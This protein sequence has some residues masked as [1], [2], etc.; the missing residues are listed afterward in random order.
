[1][2]LILRGQKGSK[3]TITEM[4]GNLSYLETLALGSSGISG[5][6]GTDAIGISGY[7]GVDGFSGSDGASGISGY[8]GV[9]GGGGLNLDNTTISFA[10]DTPIPDG[11]FPNTVTGLSD[12]DENYR[13][14]LPFNVWFLGIEYSVVYLVSN[15]YITFGDTSSSSYYD[16][17]PH[18][19]PVPAIFLGAGDNSI[20]SYRFGT[21]GNYFAIQYNGS[22]NTSGEEDSPG[23]R[24][25]IVFDSNVPDVI[26]VTSMINNRECG[27]VFGI[28]SGEDWIEQFVLPYNDKRDDHFYT[29]LIISP[30]TTQSISRMKFV[31]PGVMTSF[32]DPSK[33]IINIDPLGTAGIGICLSGD[34]QATIA[35]TESGLTLTTG[36]AG[37]SVNIAPNGDVSIQP[38]IRTTNQPGRGYTVDIIGGSAQ[39]TVSGN[40]IY[41]GG[42]VNIFGGNGVGISGYS[43]NIRLSSNRLELEANSIQFF[44]NTIEVNGQAVSFGLLSD[45]YANWNSKRVAGTLPLGSYIMVTDIFDLGGI[46]MTNATGDGFMTSAFGGFYNQDY[47][48]NGSTI[49]SDL[50]Y[51]GIVELT[52]ITPTKNV[53]QWY[54]GLEAY[55]IQCDGDPD[56]I[57]PVGSLITGSNSS[58]TGI[59]ISV[60]GGEFDTHYGVYNTSTT[61]FV[62]GDVITN[63]VNAATTTV[64]DVTARPYIEDGSIVFF[65]NQHFVI[66]LIG[67][68]NGYTP[69]D[70]GDAYALLPRQFTAMGYVVKWDKI[71]Y[72]FTVPEV[73]QRIDAVTNCIVS[74]G[75]NVTNMPWGCPGIKNILIN[76]TDINP[77]NVDF[78]NNIGT[79]SGRTS[80]NNHSVNL[81][82]NRG[83]IYFDITGITQ[84]L[85]CPTNM[86]TINAH[87]IGFS[88]G[89]NASNNRGSIS[90]YL[91][92][93]ATVYAG[94]NKG[95]IKSRHYDESYTVFYGNSG[96]INDCVFEKAGF[97]YIVLDPGFY[98]TSCKF[99]GYEEYY[100]PIDKSYI[101]KDLSS[102]GS[103][104]DLV[105]DITGLHTID[106]SSTENTFAGI[107][108]L[109][110]TNTYESIDYIIF[111]GGNKF[112]VKMV[113][114]GMLTLNFN[115]IPAATITT[116]QILMPGANLQLESLKS[117]WATFQQY[118]SNYVM[119]IDA[120]NYL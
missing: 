108:N 103:S 77:S 21:I 115:G 53:G 40:G 81:T 51:S 9:D 54:P 14:E 43:G 35:S 70:N 20:Q 7:S 67:A 61:S 86:G 74:G 42:D 107:L 37:N 33:A 22:N 95:T 80:G 15:S 118:G 50:R 5:Y 117:D 72:L 111:S 30:Q 4:D 66:K 94:S 99:S 109:S 17:W 32:N 23:I 105:M 102:T 83:D 116:N 48:S 97:F 106:I 63:N 55:G 26:K 96:D 13:I 91:Y 31:G 6:S 57:A 101:N 64:V 78:R 52:S 62:V 113:P 65:N 38:L 12:D 45:T 85:Y 56:P 112:P 119:Q 120:M 93:S 8:S 27:G 87:L 98:Y 90:T 2:S 104:F 34:G 11:D 18:N 73:I 3:L 59:I 47:A 19:I 46:L 69:D 16:I 28:S 49:T 82:Q 29:T 110:S 10:M 71:E 58:A 1:M 100:F 89:L 75:L 24:W 44:G 25:Q 76:S 41:N 88:V 68:V 92:N 60:P 36:E 39:A 114:T 84:T 79:I